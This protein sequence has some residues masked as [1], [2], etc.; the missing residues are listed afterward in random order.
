[1]KA[2][3][4][5]VVIYEE[6]IRRR[7]ALAFCD[8]LAERFAHRCVF[9]TAW[10][11][12]SRVGQTLEAEEAARKARQADWIIVA[13]R[14]GYAPPSRLAGRQNPGGILPPLFISTA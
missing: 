13:D 2:N 8:Q 6:P 12:F 9:D 14:C 10:L 11:S 4:S 5:I 1:M 3:R 7:H